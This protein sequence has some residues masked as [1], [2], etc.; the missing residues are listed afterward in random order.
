MATRCG[1]STTGEDEEEEEKTMEE[2]K[3][4]GEIITKIE[5]CVFKRVLGQISCGPRWHAA[6]LD[7]CR[8]RAPSGRGRRLLA[9]PEP[10][11]R[12][13]NI[14]VSCL[15]RRRHLRGI[16]P[17]TS[18]SSCLSF[19]WALLLIRPPYLGVEQEENYDNDPSTAEL[20]A[21]AANLLK[22]FFQGNTLIRATNW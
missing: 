9:D 8:P 1:S 21:T 7:V 16:H 2:E 3:K 11:E 4:E 10:G 15:F 12:K 22:T 13:K 17:S 20:S 6:Q 18:F 14:F 5:K 19:F